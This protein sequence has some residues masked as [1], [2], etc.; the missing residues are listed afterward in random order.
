MLQRQLIQD[1]ETR[2]MSAQLI[3]YPRIS[4]SDDKIHTA[5]TKLCTWLSDYRLEMIKGVVSL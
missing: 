5:P 3:P 2:I 1:E 4:Q